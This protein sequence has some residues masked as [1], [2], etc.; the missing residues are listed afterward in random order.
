MVRPLAPVC[1]ALGLALLLPACV[2]KSGSGGGPSD[3]PKPNTGGEL[4]SAE[5]EGEAAE[6]GGEA[7]TDGPPPRGEVEAEELADCPEGDEARRAI[8]HYCTEDGKLAGEWVPVDTLRIPDD[9]EVIFHDPGTSTEGNTELT[10]AIRGED[11]LYIRHVTCG[12]CRRVI[13]QG[14]SG[15]LAAMSPEQIR[16]LETQLGLAEDMPVLET[17]ETWKSFAGDPRGSEALTKLAASETK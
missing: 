17:T 13:G 3:E 1:A 6:A 7:D 9:A 15:H 11:E 8:A 2:V 5:P 4:E 12:Q 16:E 10:L 14:F